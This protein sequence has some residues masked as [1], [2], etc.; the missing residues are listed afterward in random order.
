MN[1]GGMLAVLAPPD[2]TP[3][4]VTSAVS[5]LAGCAT[6]ASLDYSSGCCSKTCAAALQKV[7]WGARGLRGEGG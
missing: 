3:A 7:R 2:V 1:I 6:D 5:N 4:C